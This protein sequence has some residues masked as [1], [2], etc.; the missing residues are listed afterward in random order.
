M[1]EVEILLK[2]LDIPSKWD[3]IPIHTSDVAN[4]K[5]CRRY[6]DWTSP[7]RNNLRHK[8]EIYGV[9]LN[10]WF[11]TGVHYA[12]EQYYDPMLS[13]DPVEAFLTWYQYQ[14]E[15][16]VVGEEWLDR[17]YDI[18][19]QRYDSSIDVGAAYGAPDELMTTAMAEEAERGDKW[20]IRGLRDLLPDPVEEEF[21]QHKELGVGML[22][23]FKEYAAKND[24]F[25]VVACESTYS[26]PLGFEAID[27]REDS[28]NYGKK[29]EVHARGKRDAIV[30]F[31]QRNTFAVRDY[32]TA[33]RVDEEYFLKYDKDPQALNYLWATRQEAAL[34]DLAWADGVIDRVIIDVFRKNYPKPPT[35]LANGIG[36]SV[37]RSTEGTTYDMF[38]AAVNELDVRR[39]WFDDDERAQRYADYLLTQGDD[40]FIQRH[41][42]VYNEHEV[43]NAGEQLKMVAKEMVAEDLQTYPNPSGATSCVRCAFR[44]PCL[45]A[46]DG[47]DWQ[48][49]LDDGYEEN[50]D[51]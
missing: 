1:S 51:R 50:R 17:T 7:A 4:F 29:S 21:E 9:N 18:H 14:W 31:P 5:R 41:P 2:P 39:E 45:A 35:V 34:Y 33:A 37:A 26:I 23:F 11:G 38:M 19:A 48:G 12:L 15:G 6:W 22:T 28:P 10:L 36:L 8:V 46:D 16:G 32:K 27:R 3:I 40:M 13:R 20:Y 49:M 47:S 43:W 24:D 42:A 44:S 30:W 25:E